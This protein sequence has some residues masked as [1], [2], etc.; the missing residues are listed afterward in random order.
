MAR[1]W[2]IR[3]GKYKIKL[4]G[5]KIKWIVKDDKPKIREIRP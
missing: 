3:I 5:L 2:R 1:R 4:H